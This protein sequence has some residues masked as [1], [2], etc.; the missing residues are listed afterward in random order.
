MRPILFKI[1]PLTVYSW[2]VTFVVA[3]IV[4]LLLSLRE[5]KRKNIPP[6]KIVD[7][8]LYLLV[9]GLLGSRLLFILFEDLPFYL[10]N[11]LQ[12]L[13]IWQGGL[14]YHGALLGGLLVTL[15]FSRRGKIS[16]GKLADIL[17]PALALGL[18]IGRV[19][20][21]LGGHCHGKISKL[22]WAVQFIGLAGRRHPT[23]L[24]EMFLD[25][26]VFAFIW[27]RREKIKFEGHLFL[28]YL[29]LYSLVRIFVEI[30]RESK[31][32]FGPVTYAQ[33]ISFLIIIGALIAIRR[34]R[35]LT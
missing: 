14:S 32:L 18:S 33:L 28:L 12:I 35:K 4:G 19:G 29:I 17:T 34:Q 15:W 9:G 10:K 16:L 13:M 30:F 5:A 22:P 23:Q 2:G 31:V 1:G 24:Y 7:L 26:L 20:C 25:L 21:F 6:E 27:V 3:F 8:S 11:P